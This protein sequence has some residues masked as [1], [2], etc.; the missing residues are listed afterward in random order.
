MTT[1]VQTALASNAVELRLPLG[2]AIGLQ[3]WMDFEAEN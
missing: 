2:P 3:V 1:L